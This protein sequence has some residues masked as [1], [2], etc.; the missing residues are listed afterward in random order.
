MSIKNVDHYYVIIILYILIAKIQQFY[1]RIWINFSSNSIVKIWESKVFFIW[2]L[3][4]YF[5]NSERRQLSQDNLRTGRKV[6]KKL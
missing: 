2:R 1:N 4:N 5:R 3:E 6:K